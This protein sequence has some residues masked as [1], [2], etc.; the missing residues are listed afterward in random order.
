MNEVKV[1]SY[2]VE[3]GIPE[4]PF[5][6]PETEYGSKNRLENL[7]GKAKDLSKTGLHILLAPESGIIEEKF[8]IDKVDKDPYLG[9]EVVC[10]SFL[11]HLNEPGKNI[12]NSKPITQWSSPVLVP[13]ILDIRE[14]IIQS[15]ETRNLPSKEQKVVGDYLL[16]HGRDLQGNKY[17]NKHIAQAAYYKGSERE[18]QLAI[19]MFAGFRQ[20]EIICEKV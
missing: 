6:W 5:G 12:F 17:L 2:T 13:N 18:I 9:F 14:A 1:S 10:N 3:S 7:R 8:S 4:Q 11:V 19:G 20:L 15:K 16:Q